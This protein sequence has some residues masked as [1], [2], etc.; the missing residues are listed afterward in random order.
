[1]KFTETDWCKSRRN[2]VPCRN[3]QNFKKQMLQ[4]V[5]GEDWECPLGIAMGAKAEDMPKEVKDIVMAEQ[6]RQALYQ[7]K[8]DYAQ[9]SIRRLYADVPVSMYPMLDSLTQMY[10]PALKSPESCRLAGEILGEEEEECCGGKKKQV[11]QFQCTDPKH[12]TTTVKKCQSC[13]D[14]CRR[15]EM[16][17]AFAGKSSPRNLARRLAES[18]D[19]WVILARK[20]VANIQAKLPGDEEVKLIDAFF[21]TLTAEMGL[22]REKPADVAIVE[23][24]DPTVAGSAIAKLIGGSINPAECLHR[25]G[26]LGVTLEK[27]CGGREKEVPAYGCSVKDRTTDRKCVGCDRYLKSMPVLPMAELS[28]NGNIVLVSAAGCEDCDTIKNII[29]RSKVSRTNLV[30]VQFPTADEARK[31]LD[32]NDLS[33]VYVPLLYYKEG[34]DIFK[35]DDVNEISMA[36]IAKH[37]STDKE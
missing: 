9:Q 24:M 4:Q 17:Q 2:C 13:M 19:K 29:Q 23:N 34:A 1:M 11:T 27:C 36:L 14:Y 21:M 5:G 20:T 10:I 8:S 3:D 31:Y 18:L 30:V 15:P 6:E 16:D 35:L 12:P 28:G 25:T 7:A 26:A 32:A 22:W 33:D 37:F